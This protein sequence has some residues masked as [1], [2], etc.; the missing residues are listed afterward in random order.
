MAVVRDSAGRFTGFNNPGRVPGS[1]GKSVAERNALAQSTLAAVQASASQA[2][3]ML[4]EKV[5]DGD[6]AAIRL[7]LSYVLP[8]GGRPID[9]GGTAEPNV[10][11]DAAT[12]G[13]LS[14]DEFAR[15]AQAWKSAGDAAEL[16]ELKAQIETLEQLIAELAK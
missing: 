2:V 1:F 11:I 8:A 12:S 6:M 15:M 4:R 9:L 13:V 5:A 16:R 7:V 14:P 10:L 3:R